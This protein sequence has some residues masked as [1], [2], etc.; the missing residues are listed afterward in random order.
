M[1]G[2]RQQAA[3]R[4]LEPQLH[5]RLERFGIQGGVGLAM[6]EGLLETRLLLGGESVTLI[7]PELDAQDDTAI[8]AFVATLGA[9]VRLPLAERWVALVGAQCGYSKYGGMPDGL[10]TC[11]GELG[12]EWVIER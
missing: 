11:A 12:L 6:L 10:T 4:S 8:P 7:A 1:N 2:E 5:T 9:R 3:A